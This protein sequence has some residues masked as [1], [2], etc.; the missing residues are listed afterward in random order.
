MMTPHVLV[1]GT[2]TTYVTLIRY[3]LARTGTVDVQHVRTGDVGLRALRDETRLVV[4]DLHLPGES[5][6]EVVEQLQG[7]R[8]DLP[9][10]LLTTTDERSV[11]S[12]AFGR[13]ATDVLMRG[14]NDL[15]RIEWW[16]EQIDGDSGDG[17]MPSTDTNLIGQSPAMK[18][19]Y[20][21]M[22]KALR[23]SLTVALLGESG[24]GKEQVARALHARSDRAG[25]PF[26]AVNCAAIPHDL[27]E[28]VFFGHE[29]GS[30]TGAEQKRKGH[31]EQADGGTLF[32]DEIGEL[33][34]GLQSKLLR[35]VQNR[36]IQRVGSSTSIPFDAR[37]LCA[38]NSDLKTMLEHGTFREDLYYRLFQFPI[39]LPPLRERGDDVLLLARHFLHEAARESSNPPAV[40]SPEA[41]RWMLR[42]NWPGNVRE[43]RTTVE[44]AVLLADGPAVTPADLSPDWDEEMPSIHDTPTVPMQTPAFAKSG[45]TRSMFD[46]AEETEPDKAPASQARSTKEAASSSEAESTVSRASGSE[47]PSSEAAAQSTSIIQ[48]LRQSNRA[49]DIVPL[50][51]L[52]VLAV[53][54]ALRACEGN[55]KQTAQ[56]LEVARSTVY[57]LM[58]QGE[59]SEDDE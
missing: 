13:G 19:V 49:E 15:D 2:S 3:R 39:R 43:L 7:Q 52:K 40:F 11:I 26:V 9:V 44:R 58:E 51:R 22:D 35:A 47:A 42:Y 20:R 27:A 54:H 10:L 14:N 53:Q 24:T 4:V 25:A 32:L 8:P 12:E 18:R 56:A 30:F 34:L 59:A 37:I 28:S 48:V 50:D 16:I 41:R 46:V 5:G 17:F 6:L 57:R 45:A 23:G 31:F 36:E 33:D 29:K 21:M 55:V 38:T 1:I